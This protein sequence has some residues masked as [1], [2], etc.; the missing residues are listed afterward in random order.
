[1]AKR[2]E[3]RSQLTYV[4]LSAFVGHCKCGAFLTFC[5]G[6]WFLA[7]AGEG[8]GL[9]L[10]SDSLLGAEV[11]V[12]VLGEQELAGEACLALADHAEVGSG[13]AVLLQQVRLEPGVD[14]A[15]APE[16]AAVAPA[17]GV[18]QLRS[19]PRLGLAR[20]APP[21]GRARLGSHQLLQR[22]HVLEQHV[23]VRLEQRQLCVLSRHLHAARGTPEP[24]TGDPVA[25]RRAGFGSE[26]LFGSISTGSGLC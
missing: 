3:S 2:I 22:T 11:A 6:I 23:L 8:G 5:T 19:R 18:G 1:M 24:R 16:Q 21:P 26:T 25:R 9:F 4:Q 17:A 12:D 20:A 13:A 14:A 10:G 7:A 15:G